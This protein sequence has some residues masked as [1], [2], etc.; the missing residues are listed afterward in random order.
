MTQKEMF[1]G[2]L[3]LAA[4]PY[5]AA[6]NANEDPSGTP[7]FPI[8]RAHFNVNNPDRVILRAVGLGF[9]HAYV[10]GVE[11]TGAR[12]LP[13]STDYEARADYPTGEEL[14]GHRLIVPE[15]DITRCVR[16][17]DNVL[18][19]Y[20]GG[21]WYTYEG[22]RFGD[23]KAIY[24]IDVEK[25]GGTERFFSSEK[26]RIAPGF[27]KTYH[28]TQFENQNLD[29]FDDR[30]LG[31]MPPEDEALLPNAVPAKPVETEY[32]FSECPGDSASEPFE[33][34]L[35]NKGT[36]KDDSGREIP[37]AVYDAGANIS[38]IPF[39]TIPGSDKG[40]IKVYFSEEIT[41]ELMPDMRF[42]HR[43]CFTAVLGGGNSGKNPGGNNT[44]KKRT[45][46]PAFT[47]FAF[48]YFIVEG[49]TEKVLISK[50]HA[51]VPVTSTF[52]SDSDVLNWIYR[53]YIN[54]QLSNMHAG[55]PSDCPH[56][57]RRGYTGDGQLTCHAAMS[58]LGAKE[59]Y[60]KWINDISDCQ[61][62]KT[63]HVQ[64]TAPYLHSGGG[65]GAWGCAIV[66]VPYR[67]YK[68]Y[69]DLEPAA[70]LYPQMLEYFR[71]LKD[72]SLNN[73]VVSDKKGE[74]CLGDWCTLTPTALPAGFVNNYYFIK[75]L[76]RVIELARLLGREQDIPEL[77][78]LADIRLKATGGA[79]YN[80][81]DCNFLANIQG[82]NA[83]ALDIGL[84]NE[85]TARHLVEYYRALGRYDTGICGTDVLTKVLFDIGEGD[86]AVS[87]MVSDGAFATWMKAGFTTF[88]E[89]WINST[90]DRSHSHPMFGS[91]IAY[92]FE[93]LLGITQAADSA[94]YRKLVI[95]PFIPSSLS[96]LSGSRELPCG[97]V[98]V[99][100]E[101]TDGRTR[102]EIVLP[103]EKHA[104]FV[105]G[106]NEFELSP[107]VNVFTF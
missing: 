30:F 46:S 18:A 23:P 92:F 6:T 105:F 53:A 102:C 66:E 87:L 96:K 22:G 70:R 89:Y 13:L 14:H 107:G 5:S 52:D 77:E 2:A 27:V 62:I 45:V 20:F 9:F 101:K 50:V 40:G 49:E 58:A 41:P 19:L 84:G 54:T 80:T 29:G 73:I 28:L 15:I 7:L 106:G 10:N 79:Y 35:I 3:W 55:I 11:V 32:V 43:Q 78:N 34:L 42:N 63:G 97:K 1:G 94:G 25:D 57:E 8:L 82:A 37:F 76:R 71:Y 61:D 47:W 75:S 4:G 21:G 69:G 88:S 68:E 33:P 16:E 103:A 65:P 85:I 90:C 44:G 98:S 99:S 67:F 91:V 12:F 24:C 36:K 51:D 81:W 83:F 17:G 74:W 38:A 26:D 59:F 95:K 104:L 64:Y 86:L 31:D 56:I 72:H 60:R 100:Y 48:R 93:R 39:I